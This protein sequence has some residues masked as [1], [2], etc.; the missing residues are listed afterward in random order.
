MNSRFSC[1]Y[2]LYRAKAVITMIHFHRKKKKS[3]IFLLIQRA[4]FFF[5]FFRRECSWAAFIFLFVQQQPQLIIIILWCIY[6]RD[7]LHMQDLKASKKHTH[8]YSTESQN[9][10]VSPSISFGQLCCTKKKKY[11]ISTSVLKAYTYG[12]I[13]E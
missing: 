7:C 9:E 6:R 10:T 1:S 4:F 8:F 5:F 3:S 11:C 2:V 12:V 13:K